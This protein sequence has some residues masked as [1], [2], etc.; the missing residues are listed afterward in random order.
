MVSANPM[1]YLLNSEQIGKK[2]RP[3]IDWVILPYVMAGMKKIFISLWHSPEFIIQ[4]CDEIRKNT[5]IEFV[6]LKEPEGKRLGRAGVIKYYLEKGVLDKKKPKISVN[7]TDIMKINLNEFAKFQLL[8]LGKGFLASVIVSASELSQFGKIKCDVNTK[9]VLRFEE[10]PMVLLPKDEYVNTGTFYLDSEINKYF[11][12][13]E[14]A[15]LPVDLEKSKM[16][17][18]FSRQMRCFEHV[19]PLKTWVWLKNMYDY[20]RASEID[21]ERFFEIVNIER[22]LGPY[23]PVNS[24]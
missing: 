6:Y 24:L 8:G 11:L 14:E 16:L 10:K 19:I 12:E 13:I 3:M 9:A 4:H 1:E 18:K 21:F 5:G 20:R 2:P 23:S 22:Y 15:D 17:A 7:S